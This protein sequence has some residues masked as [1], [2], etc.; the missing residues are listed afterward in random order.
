MIVKWPEDRP[1]DVILGYN[2]TFRPIS[3]ML[4]ALD[5]SGING[6]SRNM[7]FVH[8]SIQ[9]EFRTWKFGTGNLELEFL[10]SVIRILDNGL[11][12]CLQTTSNGHC[13]S[14]LG[15]LELFQEIQ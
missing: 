9:L 14:D 3:T 10:F 15:H 12:L 11:V 8:W 1:R 5:S 2:M 7:I 4:K 6:D 13:L